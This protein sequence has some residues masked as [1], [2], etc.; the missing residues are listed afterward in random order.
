MIGTLALD[1]H[2][3]G[4][5]RRSAHSTLRRDK[6]P[7]ARLASLGSRPLRHGEDFDST[8][9]VEH[10]SVGGSA[11]TGGRSLFGE[12]P[13]VNLGAPFSDMLDFVHTR[14]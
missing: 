12:R 1:A 14:S 9:V 6:R 4:G 13:P 8:S 3:V 2:V 10:A 5:R 7:A 11:S